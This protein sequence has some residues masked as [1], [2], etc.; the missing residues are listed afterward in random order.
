MT[1]AHEQRL[2]EDEWLRIKD[3]A[4]KHFVN[5]PT[6]QEA[7]RKRNR[8]RE[9]RLKETN[10]CIGA[11][12]KV[13]ESNNP[14][15]SKEEAIRIAIGLLGYLLSFVFPHYALAIQI[16]GFLWD[17]MQGQSVTIAGVAIGEAHN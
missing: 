4:L 1:A 10:R 12:R 3:A 9:K 16:I 2:K 6:A 17:I 13:M 5:E 14:P 7:P 11:F 8:F 15:K